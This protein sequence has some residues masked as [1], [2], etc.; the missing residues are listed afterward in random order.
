VIAHECGHN[1]FSDDLKLQDRVGFILHSLL[2]VPYYSWQRS[3]AVHHAQTNHIH[4]G[5][6]HVPYTERNGKSSIAR[7]AKAAGGGEGTLKAFSL[8]RVFSHLVMGWPAY[9]LLGSTGSPERG[10]SN[11]F[12][13]TNDKLF[14]GQWK[15]KVYDSSVGVGAVLGALGLAASR[16]GLPNV[17]RLYALP[18]AFTNVWLV[19]YTWMQHTHEDV[20]HFDE[21]KFSYMRGAFSTID[22]P[23]GP[24]FNWLHH[25]IGSTHVT[26]HIDCTIPH[27]HAWEVTEIIKKTWPHLYLYDPTPVM[28][29][30]IKVARDCVAVHED[31]KEGAP[32]GVYWFKNGDQFLKDREPQTA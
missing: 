16:F 27:Y 25:G 26:H 21:R 30:T 32:D 9:L 19:L 29:A 6:T 10:P 12:I 23:Y 18:Y 31:S 1:A 4:L 8:V 24:V 5:E 7:R 17:L 28:E 2:L 15:Q 20:A 22:R 13:P 14:P 11:H 3:H